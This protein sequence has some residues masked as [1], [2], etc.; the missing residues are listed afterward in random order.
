MPLY[1]LP[2]ARTCLLVLAGSLLFSL[3]AAATPP[4]SLATSGL[5]TRA[6]TQLRTLVGL[7]NA[8]PLPYPK[9]WYRQVRV[10]PFSRANGF[11]LTLKYRW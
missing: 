4:D 5:A 3:T 7:R 11:G 8:S 9:P 6:A 1:I 2:T 10:S